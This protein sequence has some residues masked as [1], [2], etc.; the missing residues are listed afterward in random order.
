MDKNMEQIINI[1][2]VWVDLDKVVAISDAIFVTPST[3]YGYYSVMFNIICSL[4]PMHGSK[5]QN[6]LTFARYFNRSWDGQTLEDEYYHAYSSDASYE[7][8]GLPNGEYVYLM[9]GRLENPHNIL[10]K[11]H[12]TIR[13][14]SRVQ[15]DINDFVSQWKTFKAT[16]K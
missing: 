10:K 1:C 3:S 2:G 13:A 14:V 15:K 6:T 7:P 11:D 4:P 9:D 16:K 8:L 5:N 12:N